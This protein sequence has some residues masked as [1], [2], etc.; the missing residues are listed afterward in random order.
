MKS[1]SKPQKKTQVRTPRQARA[2]VIVLLIILIVAF[3]V[4]FTM[5]KYAL[6][7]ED[8]LSIISHYLFGTEAT[9]STASETVFLQ[10]RLPRLLSC[11]FVGA[12]LSTAGAAYQGIFKNS[13]V[14]PDLLGASA[15]SAF[16]ACCGILM[17]LSYFGRH[18]MAFILGMVAV[19]ITYAITSIVSR[20]ENT[21]I[22][23]ILTGMVVTALF[24]AGVSIT[25]TLATTDNE[26]GEITFW[27]LGSM[28]KLTFKNL[29]ILLIPV[30][31]GLIPMFLLRYKLN[32]LSFGDEEAK[33]LG[34]N[35]KALR[36]IFIICATLV[37]SASV[38]T[39]GMVGWVGLIIPHLMR[40]LVGPDYKT[41]L[42]ASM[43]GGAL[44][45]MLVD[46]ITRIFFQVEVAIGILTA[47]IGA[48]FFLI[49]LARGRTGWV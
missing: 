31:I 5:G 16:G 37:T 41:L 44:F 13:M 38:A 25:K 7:L 34:V 2:I 33:T 22:T 11:V 20:N 42:P 46:N 8:T 24:N 3:I 17:G 1:K 4:S 32:I 23:L 48:P 19:A 21:T 9:Y 27:L 35:V 30:L 45:L 26:L 40:M 12:A 18:V 43:I 29:P 28:T 49:L 39:C 14:S 36:I 47:I 6:T 15:G 10:V